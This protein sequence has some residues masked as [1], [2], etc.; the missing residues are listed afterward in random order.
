MVDIPNPWLISYANLGLQLHFEEREI[1]DVPNLHR[2]HSDVIS[3]QCDK[4]STHW[5]PTQ[6]VPVTMGNKESIMQSHSASLFFIC[7]PIM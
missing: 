5:I 2:F 3:E 6:R 4:P 1:F 7:Q